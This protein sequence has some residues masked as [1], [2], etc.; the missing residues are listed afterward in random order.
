MSNDVY[1]KI[2][3]IIRKNIKSLA[4]EY[5]KEAGGL[6]V[7]TLLPYVRKDLISNFLCILG[8]QDPYAGDTCTVLLRN[9]KSA[10][11]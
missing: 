9:R 11:P 8:C 4:E 5:G 10:R 1:A 3:E 2:T 7:D 6:F